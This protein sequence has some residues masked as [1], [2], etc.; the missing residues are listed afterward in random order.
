MKPAVSISQNNFVVDGTPTHPGRTWNGHRV[1]GLL[2][3]RRASS[4]AFVDANPKTRDLWT[5]ADGTPWDVDRNISEFISVLPVWRACGLDAVALSLQGGP[6]AHAN[7]PVPPWQSPIRPW[8]SPGFA[9]DGSLDPATQSRFDRVLNAVADCG[10]V[11]ILNLFTPGQAARLDDEAAVRRATDQVCRWLLGRGDENV[12]VNVCQG[13]GTHNHSHSVLQPERINELARQIRDA[14]SDGRHLLV[15]ASVA[16]GVIP[17]G[18]V[19]DVLFTQPTL[20]RGS[21]TFRRAI[22]GLRKTTAF[23]EHPRPIVV[24]DGTGGD[25]DRPDSDIAIATET[26]ISW[27]L[28]DSQALE[29]AEW[30]PVNWQNDSPVGIAYL[31]TVRSITGTGTWPTDHP[32]VLLSDQRRMHAAFALALRGLGLNADVTPAGA[33]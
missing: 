12:I 17:S 32:D 24:C 3:H 28:G 21:L 16:D 13:S 11:A 20:G 31:E 1:E 18:F 29:R 15:G 23:A 2:F 25:F 19:A 27:G 4:A 30:V 10:L 33:P 6:A 9:G 8:H 22:D 26:H 14:S 5:H 7:R